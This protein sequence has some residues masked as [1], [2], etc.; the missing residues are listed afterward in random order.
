MNIRSEVQIAIGINMSKFFQ[1]ERSEG[2]GN[3]F[4]RRTDH[5]RHVLLGKFGFNYKAAFFVVH[6]HLKKHTCD[7]TIDIH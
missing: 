3:H 2:F 6:R 5:F 7:P 4:T 1:F